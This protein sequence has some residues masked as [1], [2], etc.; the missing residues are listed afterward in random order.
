[1]EYEK[2]EIFEE[3]FKQNKMNYDKKLIK[4]SY[5]NLNILFTKMN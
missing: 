4:K 5:N 2:K 3:F 1:M